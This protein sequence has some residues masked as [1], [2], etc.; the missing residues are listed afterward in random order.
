MAES[1]KT[2]AKGAGFVFA[3]ILISKII[4]YFYRIFIA[5]YFG[6]EAYGMFALALTAVG[7]A[8]IIGEVGLKGAMHR[9]IPYYLVKKDNPRVRGTIISSIKIAGL[10]STMMFIILF[11]LADRISIDFFH[12]PALTPIIKI[13]SLGV[14]FAVMFQVVSFGFRGFKRM[15][16]VVLT[17]RIFLNISN[18]FL[19]LGFAYLGFGVIG[20]AWG[21]VISYGCTFFLAVYLLD[22]KVFPF[23]F[24]KIKIINIDKEIVK[25]S[26]PMMLSGIVG[27][28]VIPYTDTIMIGYF[29]NVLDVGIYNVAL[30]TAQFLGIITASFG[31]LFFPV[32]TELHTKKK[33]QELESLC[34]T[35]VKWI[36]LFNFPIFLI[37]IIYPKVIISTLFGSEYTIGYI[38]LFFLSIGTFIGGF[39]GIFSWSFGVLKKTKIIFYISTTAAIANFLLNWVL[40]PKIGM[41]G[42]AFAS[43]ITIFIQFILAY[44]LSRK[45]VKISYHSSSLLKIGIAG[46]SSVII[47]DII[48]Q[49]LIGLG[50]DKI[51]MIFL[52]IAY[53]GT[54]FTLLLLFRTLDKEDIEI[55]KAIEKKSG[56]RIEFLR[57]F[58]KKFV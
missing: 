31:A 32:A 29:N 33:M 7:I 45:L 23:I 27:G 22:K 56:L 58:I 39:T 2:I 36:S 6:P 4:T 3:G 15:E 42:A 34:K 21:Y 38:A 8:G 12:T 48:S 9:Y 47:F 55:L 5:R 57:N 37:F 16:Y 30:P 10:S 35:T 14:P 51:I 13:M 46:I 25:Y 52:L 53:L 41:N 44:Y 50:F 54:Y 28:L 43:F 17:E 11:L 40:I 20:I 1:T 19:V 49:P 26:F 18:L 24:S